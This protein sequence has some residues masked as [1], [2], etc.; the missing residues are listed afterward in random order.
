MRV[1]YC[2]CCLFL[3]GSVMAAEGPDDFAWFAGEADAIAALS[4]D[5]TL[6]VFECTQCDVDNAYHQTTRDLMIHLLGELR[7]NEQPTRGTFLLRER[8]PPRY[9]RQNA[10]EVELQGAVRPGCSQARWVPS[11]TRWSYDLDADQAS[12]G[13]SACLGSLEE[14]EPIRMSCAGCDLDRFVQSPA[15]LEQLKAAHWAL[16]S[17]RGVSSGF[18]IIT[19][20][21]DRGFR[22]LDYR[23][24][25][26]GL[27]L[28]P[29][30][31]DYFRVPVGESPEL[32]Q[33][34]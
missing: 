6:A 1:F 22:R 23:A 24:Y 34:P 17:N 33:T 5:Q 8:T 9:Y 2:L 14:Q 15:L 27:Y 7:A 31:G 11:L 12:P 16:F 32:V 29:A 21:Q 26:A 3:S 10:G 25:P 20:S 19:D 30:D 28:G 18:I 13:T 4:Q